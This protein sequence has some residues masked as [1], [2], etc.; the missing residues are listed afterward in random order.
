[1]D[2]LMHFDSATRPTPRAP[3]DRRTAA[4]ALNG[5][6]RPWGFQRR[7][8][9]SC[10]GTSLQAPAGSLFSPGPSGTTSPSEL[11]FWLF[12]RR[13]PTGKPSCCGALPPA[14]ALLV[15]QSLQATIKD[16]RVDWEIRN[17]FRCP[18][19]ADV[20][21]P[22]RTRQLLPRVWHHHLLRYNSREGLLNPHRRCTGRLCTS[23]TT[24]G[25]PS[26]PALPGE[27]AACMRL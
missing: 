21:R 4:C 2:L 16:R 13:W 26:I 20:F 12:L 24:A 1:M 15:A 25:R 11:F 22:C 5:R 14:G 3:G 6:L 10:R 23:R 8:H 27:L 18:A 17:L 19:V 9:G 7:I